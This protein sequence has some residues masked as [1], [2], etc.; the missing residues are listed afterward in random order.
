MNDYCVKC[1]KREAVKNNLCE[2]CFL[3]S[4]EVYKFKD[5]TLSIC[6]KCGKKVIVPYAT[7]TDFLKAKIKG[8]VTVTSAILDEGNRI[9]HYKI[10]PDGFI[11][12][13]EVDKPITILKDLCQD[14]SRLASGYFEAIIQLRG[15]KDRI[16]R[17]Y[18]KVEKKLTDNKTKI[19]KVEQLKEGLDLYV[20]S[21]RITGQVLGFLKLKFETSKKLAGRINGR[22]VYRTSFLVR[23]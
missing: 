22:N 18:L 1:G 23:L 15:D 8:N 19:V 16:E 4:Y 14:C 17:T 3:D 12:S 21:T 9:I 13:L 5:V 6:P 11:H 2:E 20:F 7:L 10:L